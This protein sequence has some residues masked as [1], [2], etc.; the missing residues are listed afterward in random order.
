M[1]NRALSRIFAPYRQLDQP[2][3]P[4]SRIPG[5]GYPDAT[6][7]TVV[8]T[9]PSGAGPALESSPLQ[10]CGTRVT[11]HDVLLGRR[12]RG[13]A[14]W[15]RGSDGEPVSDLPHVGR[16][17]ENLDLEPGFAQLDARRQSRDASAVNQRL[18]FGALA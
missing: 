16:P 7:A 13:Q 17:F 4:S 18:N 8:K 12:V 5:L 15:S 10:S 11:L 6:F 3:L 1:N 9:K 14:T 2:A